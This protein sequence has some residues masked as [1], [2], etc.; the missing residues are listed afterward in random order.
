MSIE[1]IE[2]YQEQGGL[3]SR[4][5]SV[6]KGLDAVMKRTHIRLLLYPKRLYILPL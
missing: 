3:L 2:K 6:I 4:L 5:A 1:E